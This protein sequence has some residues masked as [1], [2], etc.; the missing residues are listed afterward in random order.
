MH[1]AV[2][3]A[4]RALRALLACGVLVLAVALLGAAPRM[5]RAR[6]RSLVFHGPSDPT[7]DAGVAA[8]EALGADERLR[9]EATAE[10]AS[11]RPRTWRTTAPWCSSTPPAT[12][13]TASRRARCEDF[14]EDGGGF[15]GVGRAAEGEPG[16]AFFDGLIGARPTRRA[17]PAPRRRRSWS[18]TASTRRRATCRCELEPHGRLVPLADPPDRHGPHRRALPR[19]RTR[20]PAT[21]PASAAPT[22]R[23]RGA[24]T[25]GAA[26]PSTPAWAGPRPATA[27]RSSRPP[28]RRDPV[29]AG[30]GARQLQGDDQHQL[31]AARG[32]SA[33]GP[34]A[35]GLATSGESHGLVVAPNGWV[36]YIGRGDCRTDA[37]RGALVGRPARRAS[38]TTPTRTSGSAA[39]ASTSGIPRSTTAR[40]T[41]ASRRPARSRSTATAARA[42]SAPTSRPQD[43]VGPARHHGGARLRADR[44]HLPAV[45]PELQ[46]VQHAAGAAGRAAHLEDV[47]AAD[48]ALHD[49]P[50]DQAARPRARRCGS[51]STTPRSTAAATSAAA[52][53]S[54]PQGNLYVTTGDTNSSQGTGGYSGNNPPRSARPG[55]RPRPRARTAARTRSPTRTRAGRRATPTTTTA[56][57]CGSSR[58]RRSLTAC[59]RRSAIGTTTRS[60]APT[61]RTARTCSAAPR[62]TATKPSRR[63]TRWG[64][65]TRR[66]SRSIRRPTS[67]TRRG[68]GPTPAPERDAGP[69]DVRERGPDRPCRQLWVAVLHG[70]QAGVPRPGRRRH[71]ARERTRPATSRAD[72]PRGGTD[73]WYDC[74]NLLNDSIRQ[75]RPERAPAQD[76]HRARTRA[77]SAARTSGTAAATRTTPTGAPSSRA[78]AGPTTPRTTAP[79]RASCARTRQRTA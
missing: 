71:A 49:R 36:L 22:T 32:W 37:E 70:R 66:G 5:R 61:P 67:R 56:R 44:P 28:A 17:R 41:A 76:R 51:S 43:R 74:D 64:C 30:H 10:P 12:G 78:S 63:S 50:P 26:A 46:P 59:S 19:A 69:V 62:A 40:S 23:S 57:C 13:S 25:S 6:H 18:A 72:R 75:H 7:T 11:S 73:G 20:P 24:A 14:I 4:G 2:G 9:G 45:L 54:T 77:R 68:S 34:R 33:R 1:E 42:A 3:A 27:R 60:P 21:A 15:V 65:A 52:W 31:Q 48:L 8:I 39:A 53:A 79:R 38:S 16:G 47:A 29:A 58:Y 55:R 35:T